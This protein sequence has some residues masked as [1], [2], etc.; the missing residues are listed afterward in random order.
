MTETISQF[1]DRDRGT[2]TVVKERNMM[3]DYW[4]HICAWDKLKKVIVHVRA[5]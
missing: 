1:K 3:L 5:D 4:G 2:K